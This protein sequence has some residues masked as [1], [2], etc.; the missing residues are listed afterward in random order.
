MAP[1][2]RWWEE[3]GVLP[4]GRQVGGREGGRPNLGGFPPLTVLSV[5]AGLEGFPVF[6]VERTPSWHNS[7][8]TKLQ[9]Q[10]D[11]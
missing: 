11:H 5:S 7:K 4:P 9:M 3:G 6:E 2:L 8:L 10:A 1:V